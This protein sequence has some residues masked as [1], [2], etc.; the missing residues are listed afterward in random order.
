MK[1]KPYRNLVRTMEYRTPT[2]GK[3]TA[4]VKEMFQTLNEVEILID[5]QELITRD[6]DEAVKF[7]ALK[8]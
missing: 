3:M 7:V 8:L 6:R 4:Y 5:G 2:K 1:T